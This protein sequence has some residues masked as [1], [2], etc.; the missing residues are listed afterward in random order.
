MRTTVTIDDDIF[1]AARAQAQASGMRLGK[2]ISVLARRGLERDNRAVETKNGLRIFRNPTDEIIP[3]DRV[4]KI[5][6]EE[7]W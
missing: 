3:A 2:V 7:L 5:L 6:D 4:R 1:E